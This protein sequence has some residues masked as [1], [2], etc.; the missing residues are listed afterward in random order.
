MCGRRRRSMACVASVASW[1]PATARRCATTTPHT[2]AMRAT[3]TGELDGAAHAPASKPATQ[4][5]FLGCSRCLISVR[6]GCVERCRPTSKRQDQPVA[7]SRGASKCW[8]PE[9]RRARSRGRLSTPAIQ[10]RKMQPAATPRR[11]C[12]ERH[13]QSGGTSGGRRHYR[14]ELGE[15]NS[16]SL[17]WQVSSTR[18]GRSRV[19]C[20]SSPAPA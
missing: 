13:Q 10:T 11:R 12:R 18:T 9:R 6:R 1:W 5:W 19:G 16:F 3:R 2:S 17:S 4:P 20:S 14:Q 8:E 7:C 15:A